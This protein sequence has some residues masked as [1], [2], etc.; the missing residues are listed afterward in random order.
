[1]IKPKSL[2]KVGSIFNTLVAVWMMSIKPYEIVL[3]MILWGL[4]I[5]AFIMFGIVPLYAFGWS[6]VH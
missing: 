3:G 4:F 5:L 1:M 2:A 6:K